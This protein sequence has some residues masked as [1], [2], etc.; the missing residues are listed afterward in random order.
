MTFISERRPLSLPALGSTITGLL[1][2]FEQL[3]RYA[4]VSALALALDISVF[5]LA[6]H[7]DFM[8]PPLAGALGYAMGLLLHYVLSV[9][10]V[11]DAA[12]PLK[13]R[14]RLFAEFVASGL[15]G[16]FI[17]WSII[18]IATGGFGLGAGAAKVLAIA[19]SFLGVFIV[20][21]TIIFAGNAV[22]Q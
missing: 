12:A 20:R 14:R 15:L 9:R 16:V 10:F 8:S 3:V 2:A 21:R 18:H 11:F 4:C 7:G 13:A 5:V 19:I 22:R 17:T 1:P 6:R